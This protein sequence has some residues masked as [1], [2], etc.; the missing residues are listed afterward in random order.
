MTV[1][2]PLAR[3]LHSARPRL[4]GGTLATEAVALTL[5]AWPCASIGGVVCGL[6]PISMIANG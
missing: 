2:R 1:L 5:F 4:A 3:S 6:A